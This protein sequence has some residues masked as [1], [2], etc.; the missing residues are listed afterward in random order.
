MRDIT[1]RCGLSP[2]ALYRH[3]ASKDDLLQAVV[4]LGHE[5][6][7]SRIASALGAASPRPVPRLAA[8]VRAYVTGHVTQPELAQ[9]VR[10]EYLHLSPARRDAVVRR[11]RALRAQLAGLIEEA[12]AA[13]DIDPLP[14]PDSA[15]RLAV[16]VLDMSS[17]TS[18]WYHARPDRPAAEL[19]ELYVAAAL[20]LAGHRPART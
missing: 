1:G 3:F 15:T 10:R 17:R 4:S 6:M 14:G 20:R 7:E 11:R 5:R 9:L 19:A 8:F 2:G 13:G 12:A 18:E 16:M